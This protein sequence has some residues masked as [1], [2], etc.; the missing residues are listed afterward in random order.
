M[1]RICNYGDIQNI[2]FTPDKEL[3]ISIYR[4]PSYLI[5]YR[6][7]ILLKMVRFL[8]HPV[9]FCSCEAVIKI[10][11]CCNIQRDYCWLSTV[12]WTLCKMINASAP[13]TFR[14]ECLLPLR[15][16][17]MQ[18]TDQ[19]WPTLQAAA[20]YLCDSAA[21]CYIVEDRWPVHVLSGRINLRG[22]YHGKA[23][24]IFSYAYPGFSLGE[25]TFLS[26]P[27]QKKVDDYFS[28]RYL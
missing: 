4:F 8:V 24:A 13:T 16:V 23:G 25:H 19:N 22:A 9:C 15:P 1:P 12:I 3:N 27:P 6:S 11:K 10:H 28:R 7:H 18:K 14:A 26:P 21:T 17:F 5:I 20:R 2:R